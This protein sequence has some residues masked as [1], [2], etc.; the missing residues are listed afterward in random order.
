M[1]QRNSSTDRQIR[2]QCYA[3][4]IYL[5]LIFISMII[6]IFYHIIETSIQSKVLLNPTESQYIELEQQY[7]HTLSMPY[8]IFTQIHAEY[9][10]ICSSLWISMDWIQYIRASAF[11]V[12]FLHPTDFRI[13]APGQFS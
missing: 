10:Q 2:N 4:Q 1:F 3:T 12:V 5:I 6:M 9:H 8:L 7:S 13:H 11:E